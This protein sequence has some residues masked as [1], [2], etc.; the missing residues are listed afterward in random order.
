[1][2]YEMGF[3][4]NLFIWVHGT[5]NLHFFMKKL[6]LHGITVF[7][8]CL[9]FKLLLK[10]II[11]VFYYNPCSVYDTGYNP[12]AHVLGCCVFWV[13]WISKMAVSWSGC[14]QSSVSFVFGKFNISHSCI[15]MH[16]CNYIV[17][18]F[19]NTKHLYICMF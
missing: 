15:I 2:A 11:I 12:S 7:R 13:M 19:F 10:P 9:L 6:L 16:R 17:L 5:E 18:C 14:L 1:M 8:Q 3:I 4:L